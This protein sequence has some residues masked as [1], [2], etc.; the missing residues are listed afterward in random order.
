MTKIDVGPFEHALV[1]PHH[2]VV[3]RA[4]RQHV[5]RGILAEDALGGRAALP[6]VVADEE[7]ADRCGGESPSVSGN[8][9]SMSSVAEGLAALAIVS[10]VAAVTLFVPSTSAAPA[11]A[12]LPAERH[13]R[14]IRQLTFGG[15]NAE[16]YFSPD[17]TH[18]IFQSTRDGAACDQIF[19]MKIDG[20]RRAAGQHRQGADDLRLLLSGRQG[21]PVRLDAQGRRGLP[22]EAELRARLRVADLRRLRH[23]SR[24]SRRLEPAAADDARP[25]TTPRRR[26]RPTARSPSPACATATWRSTR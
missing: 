20:T 2:R 13:L 5:E 12:P 4:G 3:A 24:Q 15:E 8:L 22:A 18:L 7:D 19:T 1:D 14:N 25:A 16:A 23:L 6:V 21:H 17:G 11:P 26:S 9:T 10:V